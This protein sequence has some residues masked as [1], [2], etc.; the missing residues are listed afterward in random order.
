METLCLYLRLFALAYFFVCGFVRPLVRFVL[1]FM[2]IFP[3]TLAV[4]QIPGGHQ[5][6]INAVW[7]GN[8]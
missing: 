2:K 4:S 7:D 8:R 3:N 1:V 5:R 6:V